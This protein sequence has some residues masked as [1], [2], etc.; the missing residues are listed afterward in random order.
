MSKPSGARITDNPKGCASHSDCFTCPFS[1]C[2]YGMDGYQREYERRQ[3]AARQRHDLRFAKED[4][5]RVMFAAGKTYVEIAQKLQI[6]DTSA[7]NYVIRSTERAEQLA[8]STQTTYQA[9]ERP[10]FQRPALYRSV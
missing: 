3:A 7:K 9:S 1:D 5:A 4:L 10:V 8:Q 2:L 6:S